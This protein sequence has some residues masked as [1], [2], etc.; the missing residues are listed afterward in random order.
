MT[1]LCLSCSRTRLCS[2]SSRRRSCYSLGRTWFIFLSLR[3]KKTVR[4]QNWKQTGLVACVW[5]FT[6]CCFPLSVAK[7]IIQ[8]AHAQHNQGLRERSPLHAEA[9]GNLT[10]CESLKWCF[11]ARLPE[12]RLQF[13]I[14]SCLELLS[15][16][17]RLLC[18]AECVS[19]LCLP[20]L[21][22]YVGVF[23]SSLLL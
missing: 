14:G 8:G 3:K 10:N 11:F 16:V 9:E 15:W 4:F 23:L 1:K 18:Q 19:S 2:Q 22:L 20:G 12:S 13:I 17:N 6:V 5:T 21:D 7:A